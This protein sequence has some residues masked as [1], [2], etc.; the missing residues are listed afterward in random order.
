MALTKDPL[1]WQ[2]GIAFGVILLGGLGYSVMST[3]SN[4]IDTNAD[5]PSNTTPYVNLREK[6]NYNDDVTE[7]N[8]EANKNIGGSRKIK[9][10]SK[11]KKSLRKYKKH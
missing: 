10:K 5:S 2:L 9:S 1:F 4:K 3:N 7:Y 11:K 6:A 8:T